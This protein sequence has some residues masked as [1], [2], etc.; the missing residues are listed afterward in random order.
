MP[1]RYAAAELWDV[2]TA[3]G[4]IDR[5]IRECFMR[6]GPVYIFLPLDLAAEMVDAELLKTPIDVSPHVDEAAQSRAVEAITAAVA[7]AKHPIVLIDALAKRFDAVHE[8]H[9]LVKRLGVPFFSANMGKG[10]VDETE[11]TYV[12]VWNG[13]VG[14]PGVKEEAAKSDLVITLGYLPADTNSAGF[15]RKLD[16]A[17]TIHVNPFDVAV[18]VSAPGSQAIAILII[19]RSKE[20]H[21]PIPPSNPF[22]RPWFQPSHLPPSIR[23]QK[24]TSPHPAPHAT[25]PPPTS[26]SPTSGPHSPPSYSP[27]TSS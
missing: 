7:E 1:L 23:C 9:Q 8:V 12:G 2:K 14:S 3:P 5:V 21:I 15:S 17:R 16:E 19:S 13:A 24:P 26:R 18:S 20:Q 27:A 10:V 4:E 11:E 6:S 22:C 25:H